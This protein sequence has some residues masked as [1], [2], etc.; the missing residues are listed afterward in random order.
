[1]GSLKRAKKK[2]MNI[3]SF[4]DY[5]RRKNFSLQGINCSQLEAFTPSLLRDH[6][7]CNDET[8]AHLIEA[9]SLGPISLLSFTLLQAVKADKEPSLYFL[10]PREE[11]LHTEL[12]RTTENGEETITL[13]VI[14]SQFFSYIL[15]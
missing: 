12:L 11:D 14:H 15:R 7:G 1:M 3:K 13:K 5:L 9:H 8:L 10:Q 6:L 2:A 4:L